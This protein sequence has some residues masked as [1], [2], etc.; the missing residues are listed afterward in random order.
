MIDIAGENLR[1]IEL[2]DDAE[3]AVVQSIEKIGK[4]I[5]TLWAQNLQNQ[6][7]DQAKLENQTRSHEKKNYNGIQH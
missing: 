7:A 5:L 4:E 1:N 2:A 6:S 3:E